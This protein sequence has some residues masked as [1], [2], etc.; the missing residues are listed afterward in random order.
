MADPIVGTGVSAQH[1]M[2]S[3]AKTKRNYTGQGLGNTQWGGGGRGGGRRQNSYFF[4]LQ[5]RRNYCGGMSVGIVMQNTNMFKTSGRASF[6]IILIQFLQY[7][8]FVVLSG[9]AFSPA[10]LLR[11]LH[12]RR[13][14]TK[15]SLHSKNV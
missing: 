12:H 15:P 10:L 14:H 5:K 7:Y 4:F 11:L 2:I 3:I 9:D 8:V 13:L 6:L 1:G